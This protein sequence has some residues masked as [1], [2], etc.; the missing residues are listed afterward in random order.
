MKQTWQLT[1]FINKHLCLPCL[2]MDY[3]FFTESLWKCTEALMLS[4]L[5]HLKYLK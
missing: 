2:N 3:F 1:Y 5:D 4:E